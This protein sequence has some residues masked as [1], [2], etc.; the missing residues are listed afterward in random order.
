MA[1]KK[2]SAKSDPTEKTVAKK[3]PVKKEAVAPKAPAKKK[4][5]AKKAPAKKSKYTPEQLYN[6][7]E[8]A[9]YYAAKND[10]F[11]KDPSEYWAIAE[12]E[13]ASMN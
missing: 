12:K 2:A 8:K 3:A 1:A 9:A 11:A 6:M 5:A 10:N 4:A 7:T 13:I